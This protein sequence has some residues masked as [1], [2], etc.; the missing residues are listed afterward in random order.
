[1]SVLSKLFRRRRAEVRESSYTDMV[2]ARI[3]AGASGA[4]DG[5]GLWPRL[6]PPPGG[7]EAGSHPQPSNLTTRH[8]S[9]Y[10]LWSSTP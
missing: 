2:V 10:L 6:K 8:S 3:M 4:S 9:P 7:G 1:M 5:G